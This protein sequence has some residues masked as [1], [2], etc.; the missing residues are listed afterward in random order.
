[1]HIEASV[2]KLHYLVCDLSEVEHPA[3]GH[4]VGGVGGL[5]LAEQL[6]LADLLAELRVLHHGQSRDGGAGKPEMKSQFLSADGGGSINGY[7]VL[8]AAAVVKTRVNEA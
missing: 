1:M 4:A 7:T 3:E 8:A 6:V 2:V 5:L